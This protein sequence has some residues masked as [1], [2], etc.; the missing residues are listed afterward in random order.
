MR[1][2]EA[3]IPL[4]HNH[5]HALAQARRLRDDATGDAEIRVARAREFVDFFH[6]DSVEHFRAEEE[7]VFPLVVAH[8]EIR[9]L[10]MQVLIE[11]L[12]IR[13]LVNGLED[14]LETGGVRGGTL[15]QLSQKLEEHVRLEE[16][17]VF[18]LI[19]RLAPDAL[20]VLAKVARTA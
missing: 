5:H 4:S 18:P 12:E 11:H 7:N 19:E 9:P 6:N 1:R 15:I 20:R 17:K 13:A 10:L 14:E 3:L 8:P 2:H 16:K